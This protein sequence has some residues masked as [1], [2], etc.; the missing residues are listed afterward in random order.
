MASIQRKLI[1]IDNQ[2]ELWSRH[3]ETEELDMLKDIRKDLKRL[4]S[5]ESEKRRKEWDINPYGI[6]I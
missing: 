5:L 2:I 6:D 1:W 4:D 3:G